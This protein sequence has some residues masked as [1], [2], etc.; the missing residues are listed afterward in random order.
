[1]DSPLK[2]FLY[3]ISDKFLG[4]LPSLVAGVVLLG[5]GLLLG[6]I[7]KRIVFQLSLIFRLDK[8]FRR[9]RWG[10]A[11]TKADIR[12]AFYESLGRGAF[13]IILLVFLDAAFNAL[14][15]Q[16][17]SQLIERGVFIVPRLFVALLIVGLGWMV[18]GWAGVAVQR[19]LTKEDVPRATLIARFTK[20]IILLFVSAMALTELDLAREIVII[21]F[22]VVIITL[23]VLSVVIVVLGGKTAA[24]KVLASLAEE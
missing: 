15:L 16:A 22:T 17:L 24:R 6:W 4:Y 3:S 2:N 12:Y 11:L 5:V 14:Q 23:G 19:A 10:E 20:F 18:A 13:W 8:L 1:M 7:A 21:G 9:T